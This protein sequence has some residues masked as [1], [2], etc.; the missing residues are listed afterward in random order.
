MLAAVETT[1]LAMGALLSRPQ[2]LVGALVLREMRGRQALAR[3]SPRGRHGGLHGMPGHRPVLAQEEE[4][5]LV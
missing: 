3:S 2:F 5:R 4:A 1:L